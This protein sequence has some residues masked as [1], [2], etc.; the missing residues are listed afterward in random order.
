MEKGEQEG[1]ITS[2][3]RLRTH[4][5]LTTCVNKLNNAQ[6]SGTQPNKVEEDS[7]IHKAHLWADEFTAL[8]REKIDSEFSNEF[9]NYFKSSK[10]TK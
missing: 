3:R 6:D 4:S 10:Q 1:K 7:Y 9:P 5:K 2:Q 8:E